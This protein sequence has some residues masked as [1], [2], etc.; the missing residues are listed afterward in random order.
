MPLSVRIFCTDY[1][2]PLVARLAHELGVRDHLAVFGQLCAFYSNVARYYPNG[3]LD[4]LYAPGIAR[5]AL[6][7]GASD[8]F[9]EAMLRA[10]VLCRPSVD[11]HHHAR[12][13]ARAPNREGEPRR[14]H[15]PAELC[16]HEWDR[17]AG[18][19]YRDFV[20]DSRPGRRRF[21]LRPP[22]R[23]ARAGY[24]TAPGGGD[25]SQARPAPT[26]PEGMGPIQVAPGGVVGFTQRGSETQ[27]R[28]PFQGVVS[29]GAPP[30]AHLGG[31]R[32]APGGI[33]P[34]QA[35]KTPIAPEG[36]KRPP[37]QHGRPPEEE[38]TS[39]LSDRRR[40]GPASRRGPAAAPR[41]RAH[42]DSSQPDAFDKAVDRF[43]LAHQDVR[44][45][46]GYAGMVQ[47]FNERRCPGGRHPA[48][49]CTFAQ[50]RPT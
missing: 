14:A 13:P 12:C 2:S 5:L 43:F 35:R 15:P 49:P 20:S 6:W 34:S 37:K 24:R 36:A 47:A 26:A 17:R 41:G 42:F 4:G 30:G 16:V 10:G 44:A 23:G 1:A 38:T 11:P 29:G 50:E 21:L 45:A 33:E 40:G 39:P 22:P 31:S 28:E 46:V 18:P 19:A 8:V 48:G 32:D 7:T 3:V 9:L 25:D 27:A